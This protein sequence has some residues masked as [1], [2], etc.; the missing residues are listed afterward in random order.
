MA[1]VFSQEDGNLSVRPIITSRSRAYADVDLSFVNK[2][3]GD[4]Y[5][6]NDGA[7]VK[8][9]VKNLLLTNHGEKPFS[10]YFGGDLNRFLFSLSEEFDELEI[11]DRIATAI[12]NE[13]PRAIV[14]GIKV[15]LLPD[16]N[17]VRVYVRFQVINTEE[18]IELSVSL[19]RLR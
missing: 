11:K 16:Q 3:S 14:L 13:E 5:K 10:P 1:R 19:A 2:P 7:A 15:N 8:Q 17:S 9:A 6:K 18:V 12:N 4:I